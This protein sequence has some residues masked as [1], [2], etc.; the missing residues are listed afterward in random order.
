MPDLWDPKLKKIHIT[1]GK[2]AVPYL[3]KMEWESYPIFYERNY[4]WMYRV[5]KGTA[6]PSGR[7]KLLFPNDFKP[8]FYDNSFDYFRIPYLYLR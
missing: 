4:G 3:L 8:K 7:V 2:N 6:L 5:P 1:A